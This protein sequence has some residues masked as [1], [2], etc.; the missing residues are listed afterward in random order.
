MISSPPSPSPSEIP[1]QAFRDQIVETYLWAAK[2]ADEY[3][4]D[5]HFTIDPD[6]KQYELT[7]RGRQ[8]VRALPKPDLVRTMGLVDLYEYTERA[9]KAW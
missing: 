3:E 9:V 5:D 4:L 8:K 7:A 1:S 2:H 6:T